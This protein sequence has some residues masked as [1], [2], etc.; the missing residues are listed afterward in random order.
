ERFG[1]PGEVLASAR[2]R[3]R[4]LRRREWFDEVRRDLVLT[5]RRAARSPAATLLTLATLA[6]A[7]GLTTIMFAFVDRVL[8][9][10]L[11]FASPERLV[12]LQGMDSSGTAVARTSYVNWADWQEQSRSL[13][14]SAVHMGRELSVVQGGRAR[15]VRGELVTAEF[16][17]VVRPRLA[18]GRGFSAEDR[19]AGVVVVSEAY[20]QRELGG[21]LGPGSS[22]SLEGRARPVVGVVRRGHEYPADTEVWALTRGEP[23]GGGAQRNNINWIAIARLAEGATAAS[24]ARELS[25][26]ARRI[27]AAEPESDY[28]HGVA[29]LGLRDHLVGG[30]RGYLRLLLGAVAYVLLIA[31][32]NLAALNLAR[33]VQRRGEVALRYALGAGRGRLVRQLVTEQLALALTGGGLGL[34]LAWVAT[35]VLGAALAGRVPRAAEVSVDLRIVAFTL[36]LALIAGML[37]GVAPAWRTSAERPRAL[38]GGRG[39]VRGGR[40]MPGALLVLAEV[41]MAVLLLAGAGLLL[42]SFQAVLARDVGFVASDRAI[43]QIQLSTERYRDEAARVVFWDGLQEQLQRDPAVVRAAIANWV[44]TGM[45]GTGY[46]NVEG[47]S[48]ANAGAAYRVIGEGYFAALG[49]PVL[50]G[51]DLEARD[52]PAAL[53]VAVIS[54]SLAERYWPGANPVGR[55]IQVPGMEG[56]EDVPWLTIV[57]V[58]GDVRHDGHESEVSDHV[59]VSWRQRPQWTQAMNVVVQARGDVG[60]AGHALVRA[61]QSLDRELAVE[62]VPLERE[63][64]RLVAE[65]RLVMLLLAFFGAMA[66]ALAAVGLY[67]ILSFAVAQRTHEIGVRAALGASRSGIVRMVV[68]NAGR[69][70]LAGAAAGIVAAFWLTRVLESMLVDVTHADPLTYAA[71]AVVLAL[72]ALGAV[73]LP[74]RRAAHVDPLTALRAER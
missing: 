58:V 20:L 2:Q 66:L 16:F 47:R 64:G 6:L 7:I 50:R 40:G 27:Q 26:I 65:R 69:V 32:A 24:A 41:S 44:P 28:S 35:D 43:A 62:P 36:G 14:A 37:T 33:G 45:G 46:L 51:R 53:R 29:V 8:L 17:D 72:V 19:D 11:P 39:F 9:R 15:H 48:E 52:G 49:I 13:A 38:L 3:E 1:D 34:L 63:L 10:P 60:A 70:V 67:G 42:R 23:R 25:A 30:A 61:A 71:A 74:A 59:Y 56:Y 22:L 21:R 54:R 68:L 55:R 5:W 31:C 18:S 57:G 12:V 4:E 73:F